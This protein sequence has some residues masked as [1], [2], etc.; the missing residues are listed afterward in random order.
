MEIVLCLF[1]V[2]TTRDFGRAEGMSLVGEGGGDTRPSA[3]SAHG[4]LLAIIRKQV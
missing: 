1:S 4:S 2:F 3:C